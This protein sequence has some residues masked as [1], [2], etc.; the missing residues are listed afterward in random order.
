M[1]STSIRRRTGRNAQP[2]CPGDFTLVSEYRLCA[3][4][5]SIQIKNYYPIGAASLFVSN[6]SGFST[7]KNLALGGGFDTY[8]LPVDV[9]PTTP[10]IV[11]LSGLSLFKA[12][13]DPFGFSGYSS[14]IG[15]NIHA[16]HHAFAF[17]RADSQVVYA[18]T[19]GGIFRSA[20]GG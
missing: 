1:D 3:S 12:I 10:A 15:Q 16:D 2:H 11:Y 20:D 7:V 18:G 4:G 19:D 6:G 13:V 17:D 5:I 9:D 8:C 14:D